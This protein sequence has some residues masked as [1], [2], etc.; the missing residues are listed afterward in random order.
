MDENPQRSGAGAAR[1]NGQVALV[2]GASRGIGA[3]VAGHLAS[4]GAAVVCAA[5][6]ISEG[7]NPHLEGSLASTVDAIR[8][9]GGLATAVAVDLSDETSCREL[10][11][12]AAAAYDRPV[13]ILVNNAAVGFFGPAA[14]LPLKRWRVS[15]EVTVTAPLL[16]SQLVLPGMLRRGTG[17]ILNLTSESAV[18]PGRA[19]YP[20]GHESVGDTAYGAQKAA[21][22]RLTQGLA[23]EV[24]DGG[25][26]V[27]AI[28]PSQIVPT[29]GA[30]FNR[31]ITGPDDPRAEPPSYLA[32]AIALLATIPLDEMA[33]RVVYSQQ[34]LAEYGLLTDGT[35]RGVDPSLPISGFALR[36]PA[37]RTS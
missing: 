5:R 36:Q 30:V 33:G 34:L 10:V 35:G 17:R 7:D 21:V 28:A 8:A 12:T 11:E 13:D 6:T 26:G 1:L 23:E 32:E 9:A 24:F 25:V 2:T 31:I 29:P 20:D 14:E 27:A 3:H 16:L 15:W 18:G 19:P 37:R 22:E 4:L